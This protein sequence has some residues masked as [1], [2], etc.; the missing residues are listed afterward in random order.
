MC[1]RDSYYAI[2]PANVRYDGRLGASEELMFA[3][4]TALAQ[5]D[6]YAFAGNR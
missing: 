6:G 1:I 3:E 4:L 5:K 2:L